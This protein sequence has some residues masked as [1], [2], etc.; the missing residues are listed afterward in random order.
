M[1][2]SF[3]EAQ[4]FREMC[5][6]SAGNHWPPYATSA[7]K[8]ALV[9]DSLHG[10]YTAELSPT[11]RCERRRV[12]IDNQPE[13]II[14]DEL[15]SALVDAN[16]P[17]RLFRRGGELVE[18]VDEGEGAKIEPMD[19]DGLADRILD[20]AD[21]VGA[22]RDDEVKHRKLSFKL[23]SIIGAR[24]KRERLPRLRGLARCPFFGPGGRLVH[25]A[26][27]DAKSGVWLDLPDGFEMPEVPQDATPEQVREAREILF[28]LIRDFPFASKSDRAHYIAAVTTPFI[29]EYTGGECAPLVVIEAPKKGSGKSLLAQVAGI[30]SEGRP[31]AMRPWSQDENEV[32]KTIFATLRAGS[33]LAIFDNVRGDVRSPALEAVLTSPNYQDRVLGESKTVELEN[34]ALWILTANNCRIAGDLDRR[35]I[36]VRIDPRCERPWLRDGFRHDDLAGWTLRNRNRL[37]WAVC[38]LVQSWLDAGA[39]PG[40][41]RPLGSF[42]RWSEALSGIMDEAQIEGFLSEDVMDEMYSESD[43]DAF[44]R[45]TFIEAWHE[46]H[47]DAGVTV[48]DLYELAEENDLLD[49][50]LS[51]GKDSTR[52]HKTRIGK[53][54][55]ELKDQ[56]FDLA[57]GPVAVVL[58]R[59]RPN[60]YHLAAVNSIERHNE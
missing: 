44:E 13:F 23:T 21:L 2:K 1:T 56:V 41:A 58:E 24:L 3:G 10:K 30:I 32:R 46:L 53:M 15:V 31:P 51:R 29:R 6:W 38:T 16:D 36:R 22:G 11:Q 59:G 37:C 57:G 49:R 28:E 8:R 50:L 20:V 9:L 39:L 33:R 14:R 54:L 45:R 47:G 26:G 7:E 18:V 17:P 19:R 4:I 12:L 48:S 43:P 25:R 55:G 60:K 42:R 52:A 35:S 34:R 27:Y 5:S 40:P